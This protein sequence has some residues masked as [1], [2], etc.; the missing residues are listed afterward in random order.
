MQ[1]ALSK[2]TEAAT[3]ESSGSGLAVLRDD[4][5]QQQYFP[6]GLR[7]YTRSLK[8]S[9]DWHR[10]RSSLLKIVDERAVGRSTS[11]PE[12]KVLK[13]EQLV[14]DQVV[15]EA[16]AR[17]DVDAAVRWY[18]EQQT[19]KGGPVD[20]ALTVLSTLPPEDRDR[21][22][23]W[24]ERSLGGG[25][26]TDELVVR[27]AQRFGREAPGSTIQRL[28]QIPMEEANRARILSHFALPRTNDKTGEA[29][30]RYP[31]ESLRELIDAAQLSEGERQRWHAVVNETSYPQ[32]G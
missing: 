3:R 31:P 32:Q 21:A 20:R 7:G 16:W 30:L 2:V 22:V 9:V 13:W 19:P 27:Y 26:T 23:H 1:F 15:A 14:V 17:R 8:G 10:V 12:G 28:I 5:W 24:L 11:D 29:A 18:S 6:T 25:V 4:L